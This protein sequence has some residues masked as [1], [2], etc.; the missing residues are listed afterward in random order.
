MSPS[1]CRAPSVVLPHLPGSPRAVGRLWCQRGMSLALPQQWVSVCPASCPASQ[2]AALFLSA[3]TRPLGRGAPLL[4]CT[5]LLC[6]AGGDVHPPTA[7]SQAPENCEPHPGLAS[8]SPRGCG[9]HSPGISPSPL[10]TW[11]TPRGLLNDKGLDPRLVRALPVPC[12]SGPHPHPRARS[13]P[14]VSLGHQGRSQGCRG[15]WW[16]R[17]WTRSP[18]AAA[19]LQADRVLTEALGSAP[20]SL[21]GDGWRQET[22]HPGSAAAATAVAGRGDPDFQILIPASESRETILLGLGVGG[23]QVPQS[24]RYGQVG[25]WLQGLGPS[26]PQH[27]LCHQKDPPRSE[28]GS[29]L[30]QRAGVLAVG[31]WYTLPAASPVCGL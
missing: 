17:H 9:L 27:W 15:P 5:W 10:G 30:A 20:P 4:P 18:V 11:L 24:R 12:Q 29:G 1:L 25:P 28:L 2:A 23:T 7:A 16:S 26:R 14:G 21:S 19:A 13:C 3:T 22:R 31:L 8:A 6:G